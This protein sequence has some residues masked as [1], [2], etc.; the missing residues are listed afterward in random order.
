[1]LNKNREYIEKTT[2]KGKPNKFFP[3]S[4][5]PSFIVDLAI[6]IF[7]ACIPNGVKVVGSQ[8][9]CLKKYKIDDHDCSVDV[10]NIKCL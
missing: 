3:D 10:F 6:K 7:K 4:W 5:E 8:V 2:N 9:L 1:M